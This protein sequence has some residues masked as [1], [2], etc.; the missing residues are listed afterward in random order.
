MEEIHL[1][2]QQV[3]LYEQN[4]YLIPKP[5]ERSQRRNDFSLLT[6]GRRRISED[7]LF[8]VFVISMLV[9]QWTLKC[10]SLNAA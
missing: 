8:A 1:L 10:A 4:C 5:P 6:P 2:L 9:G 3:R 7:A